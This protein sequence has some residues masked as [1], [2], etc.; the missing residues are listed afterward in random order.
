MNAIK[1]AV[2]KDQLRTEQKQKKKFFFLAD[3]TL[4]SQSNGKNSIRVL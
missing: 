2:D 1:L 4:Y 3:T